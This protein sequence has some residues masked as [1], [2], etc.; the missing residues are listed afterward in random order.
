MWNGKLIYY[1]DVLGI[2][3]KKHKKDK[4]ILKMECNNKINIEIL[5]SEEQKKVIMNIETL[6]ASSFGKSPGGF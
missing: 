1:V 2:E 3:I 6:V 5:V 4:L